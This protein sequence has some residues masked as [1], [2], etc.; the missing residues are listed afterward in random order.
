MVKIDKRSPRERILEVALDLF[1]RQGYNATGIN[2]IIREADC[3]RA[4]FY[5]HFPS[6]ADLY[7]AYAAEFSRRDI[8]EIRQAVQ[9]LPT[10]RARFFGLFDLLPGWL[11]ETNYRGCPFQN[12]MAERPADVP[13]AAAVAARH[14]DAIRALI[15]ELAV[16]LM[17]S[18]TAYAEIDPDKIANRYLVAFEGAIA[19]SVAFGDTW[20]I[21]EARRI[22]QESVEGRAE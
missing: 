6:K 16:D 20:P 21:E 7:V 4:S 10:A 12:I 17:H 19:S 1:Y 22:L 15:R 14:R 2:Q 9:A 3:A 5:E 18:A 13:A 11:A 8:A